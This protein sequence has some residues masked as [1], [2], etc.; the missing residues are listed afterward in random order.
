MD[1]PLRQVVLILL[2]A[3]GVSVSTLAFQNSKL[4]TS[5]LLLWSTHPADKWENAFPVGNGR[6]GAM[7]FGRTDQEQIQV[8]EDTYWSGGPYSTV[9]KGGAQVLP[10]L[11]KL[12]FDGKYKEAH[13]LFGRRFMGYPVEQQKYQALGN[14][15][16]NFPSTDAISDY[17]HQLNLDTAIVTTSYL[18]GGVRYVREVFVSPVDQVVVVRLAADRPGKINFKAQLR[19]YRN[20]AHSNY[21]TDYFQMDGDGPNGLMLRGKSADYLGIEG[22]LRYQAR[23]RAMS[24]GGSITVNGDELSVNNASA[25]TLLIAAA[26]NFVNY[27]DVSAD[28]QA[29]V[30]ATL[31]ALT[32]KSFDTMK[33][34]HVQE[35]QRLFRR[36]LLD[37]PVTPL[38]K[39]PTEERL[40]RFDGSNDP[41]LATL[42][43]QFGRYL[44]ISSS[45][46]GSQPANLQ[47]IWNKDMNPPWDAKYTTNINT[48]MN[49]WPAEV[50]NL[51]ECA[52]PLF[53]MIKDLTDQGSQVAREHY[54]ARGW[55]FHQ[56][57]D[58]W[59]VAAPMDGPSWGT[60][61][62]GGAWLAT[63]LWEHYLYTGDKIFLKKYYPVLKGSAEFYLDFLVP[64]PKYGWLVTNPSTSPENFPAVPGQ[65]RFFDETTMFETG[66]SICAGSTID[67]QILNDLFSAVAQA[68]DVLDTDREFQQKVLATRAKL[69]P[70]QVGKKGNLQEW[71]EDWDETE[72]SHRH[73]SGLWGL[74]PGN[75][76]ST[77]RTPKLA[78]ASKVVLEQRGLPGNGWSS[79]WKA[80]CWAR[81]GNAAKAQENINY[82]IHNY[83]FNSMF[84]ICSKA[85]QVDGSFGMS[86]VIAELLLQ[87]HENE[88]NLLP[89]LPA[90]WVTGEVSGLLARGGF[91]VS[92]RWRN[93][94]L[95]EAIILSRNGNLCRV[96][97]ATVLQVSSQRKTIAF[98]RPEKDVVEF[99]TMPGATYKLISE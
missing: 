51:S 98:T 9:M 19:G 97:A 62:T 75:Q 27:K 70:M 81:L 7:V 68:A 83:T 26:T 93:G 29:R 25:V 17:R 43:F 85:M 92:M 80:A 34:E 49:Y 48:Q 2:I 3:L 31:Q 71:L 10:E 63:H 60:F 24:T 12:I 78:E 23:L 53:Q 21:A 37:L 90:S 89:A 35:H 45:R 52:E 59:R 84:S 91:E 95:N 14:L 13:V 41:A 64:H 33:T 20:T 79:A 22:K 28:P 77:R 1:T 82:A 18:Q 39:L 87:S 66:T 30:L 5:S 36:V 16:L 73:I 47:G 76:I 67:M 50:A 88:L 72:K 54:G 69:A 55:V 42:L 4:S 65:L 96:R 15:V 6:L 57:T 56:N 11:Q 99:K 32:E 44:L 86:A 40:S 61:T 8:N 58:L 94:Q 46:P 74:F 38:S